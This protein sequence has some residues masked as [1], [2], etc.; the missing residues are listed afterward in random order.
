MPGAVA[1]TGEVELAIWGCGPHL[2]LP[3]KGHRRQVKPPHGVPSLTG[4]GGTW[5]VTDGF[6]PYPGTYAPAERGFRWG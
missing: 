2:P 3:N 5:R 4:R 6:H 1:Y